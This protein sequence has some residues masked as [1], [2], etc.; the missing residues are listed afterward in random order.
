VYTDKA[1]QITADAD[2]GGSNGHRSD[3]P[4]ATER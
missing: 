4:I 2:G 3:R 1:M